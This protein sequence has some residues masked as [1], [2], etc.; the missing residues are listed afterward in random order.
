MPSPMDWGMSA[1]YLLAALF[2]GYLIGSIPFGL[3]LTRI[4]GLGDI[5][6]IGSGNIGATNVLRTG[7]KMLAL[8]T[9]LLDGGKGSVAV[10]IAQN[11]GADVTV[12][13]AL[14]AFMGHVFPVWL[15]FKGG[16][17]VATFLGI[18]LALNPIVGVAACGTWLSVAA[19]SRISSAAA[20][21]AAALT[22]LYFWLAGQPQLG[23]L[24]VLLA[25]CIFYTHRDNIRRLRKGV[26]PKIGAR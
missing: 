20:L 21:S 4:A 5:R 11:Y 12:C 17:G 19:I 15:R 3:L 6:A 1:P 14:G 22:P 2:A 23:Q 10:L 16:K 13:T 26:E 24:A 8:L 7:N 18:A 9:L 25:V